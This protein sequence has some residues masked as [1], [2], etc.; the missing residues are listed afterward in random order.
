MIITKQATAEEGE[1]IPLPPIVYPNTRNVNNTDSSLAIVPTPSP[2]PLSLNPPGI[3]LRDGIPVQ[4]VTD[5]STYE[6]Y[7]PIELP[8]LKEDRFSII[9]FK[10][11]KMPLDVWKTISSF[12]LWSHCTH[13]SEA[14]ARFCYNGEAK[15]WRVL[16]LP[17]SLSH[18]LATKE[19]ADSDV[20]KEL[21]SDAIKAGFG[22]IGTIHH[23]CNAGAFQSG[24][25]QNDELSQN[26]LH[27]TLG[28]LD[29]E[30]FT[31]N[32]RATFRKLQYSV[33][34]SEWIAASLEELTTPWKDYPFPEEWKTRVIE[35]KPYKSNVWFGS[36][37]NEGYSSEDWDAR[38]DLGKAVVMYDIYG[39]AIRLRSKK[40]FQIKKDTTA[41]PSLIGGSKAAEAR[42]W[43][44]ALSSYLV[45]TLIEKHG[46]I[47]KISAYLLSD[48]VLDL[49]RVC[50]TVERILSKFAQDHFLNTL[51]YEEVL[52]SIRAM[53]E[54][55]DLHDA[56]ILFNDYK[57]ASASLVNGSWVRFK[58]MVADEKKLEHLD[59]RP[60]VL[61][62]Q[63]ENCSTCMGTGYNENYTET[64]K[65][66]NG[67][68]SIPGSKVAA[69]WY[70]DIKVPDVHSTGS[71]PD[72]TTS[73]L[74]EDG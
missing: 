73:S 25:D 6:G 12:M 40:E 5:N 47:G 21:I 2:S 68:G 29:K 19:I 37:F 71:G 8:E 44:W 35:P 41:C 26:G 59:V 10:G 72:V 27:I 38:Q 23:H 60:M 52:E 31:L 63:N 30:Y 51:S 45:K 18:G 62:K 3:L 7:L 14:Q 49:F 15:T 74:F 39:N 54:V 46:G 69:S 36:A 24:M 33:D 11:T 66:C 55:A 58:E 48:F 22:T 43:V 65:A 32:A 16:V 56:P 4:L 20:R 64:C 50:R 70:E 1:G 28:N 34:L 13:K 67:S 53:K 57:K 61:R 9:K 42:F 17:Q